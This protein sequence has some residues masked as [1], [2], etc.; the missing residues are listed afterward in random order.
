VVDGETPKPIETFEE[1]IVIE[2][3]LAK[4]GPSSEEDLANRLEAEKLKK[5]EEEE[6]GRFVNQGGFWDD[7]V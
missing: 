2:E 3:E 1:S 4:D 6:S 5:E 7:A